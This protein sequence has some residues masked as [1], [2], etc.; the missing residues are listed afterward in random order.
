[1][2]SRTNGQ[3][4]SRRRTPQHRNR[5]TLRRTAP[6]T[7]APVEHPGINQLIINVMRDMPAIPKGG[8]NEDDDYYF[9]RLDDVIATLHDV[10]SEH[11]L[12]VLPVDVVSQHAAVKREDGSISALTQ[13]SVT[14]SYELTGVSGDSKIVKFPGMGIDKS[15]KSTQKAMSQAW[16]YLM[17]QVFMIPVEELKEVIDADATTPVPPRSEAEQRS[18][19]RHP[20]GRARQVPA[21]GRN[22]R[23]LASIPKQ[24]TGEPEAPA[25][26]PPG[27]EGNYLQRAVNCQTRQE[28]QALYLEA[29]NGSVD[30][31]TV[32]SL[33]RILS[34]WKKNDPVNPAKAEAADGQDDES[35][36]DEQ[37]ESETPAEAPA[38]PPTPAP[39]PS[40]ATTAH[41]AAIEHLWEFAQEAGYDTFEELAKEFSNKHGRALEDGTIAQI[42][43][44]AAGMLPTGDPTD[45]DGPCEGTSTD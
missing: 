38:V 13:T 42:E 2:T 4:P 26:P 5:T 32:V 25:G 21:Q 20:A 3:R 28:L 31:A 1:M 40:P 41:A 29:K 44:F 19:N 8:H 35:T 43:S 16:K 24:R 14:V 33:Q 30:N 10:C 36:G 37:G 9:R 45:E 18:R 12:L 39:E 7:A 6:T 23:R 34:T 22:G 11:G 17:T 27:G 15:D